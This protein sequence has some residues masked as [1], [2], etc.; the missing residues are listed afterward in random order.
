MTKRKL[1]TIA[2]V[3]L[4]P[5]ASAELDFAEATIASR[6]GVKTLRLPET[7]IPR[8][9]FR[10]DRGQ[11]DADRL[12]ELLFDMLP[13]NCQ[14]IIGVLATDMF[15]AGRTFV[16]GYGH[17]RDGMAVYSTA[18]F[19]EEWYGRPADLA[20]QQSRSLRCIVHELGHTFGN[21]HCEAC[22]CI[23][24]AVSGLEALDAL[25]ETYC[26]SCAARVAKALQ[27]KPGSAED[28]FIRAG[29]LLRRRRLAKAVKSYLIATEKAPLEPRYWNDLGVASLSIG[30]SH[31]A[32]L[33]FERAVEL[34]AAFPHPYYN[35]GILSHRES[36]ADSAEAY[37]NQGLS[38]DTNPVAA[39]RYLGRLYEELFGDRARAFEHYA[40][41]V[42]MGGT[43]HEV[44]EKYVA[45]LLEMKRTGGG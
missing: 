32:K 39:H 25:S 40:A 34:A 38:R 41:Y 43:E 8:S 1:L 30:D 7:A 17:L 15:A 45:L 19:C 9:M 42:D 14:R 33:A 18:R 31:R 5:V 27:L 10:A 6:F 24:R 13:D 2:V 3:P 22:D 37:L 28:A 4:G 23:M 44:I 21:P 36:G 20:K 11:W 12:L 16:F 35:L 26:T 29:A